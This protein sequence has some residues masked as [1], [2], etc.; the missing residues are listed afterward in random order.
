MVSGFLPSRRR[1]SAADLADWLE[2]DEA[3]ATPLVDIGRTLAHRNHGRTRSVVMAR[4]H[5]EALKGLRAIADNK[6]SPIVYTCDSPDSASAVWLLSG[7]GSQHRK[8]A[9]QL[10]TE[11]PV[12]AAA[13]DKVDALIEDEL[14][15][16]MVEMFLD[17]S[18][19]YEIETSQVGIFT[20]QVGARRAAAPPR[21]RC[22][23]GGRTFDG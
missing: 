22:R 21:R 10:Y 16:S 23:C 8:M 7:F 11:N 18:I 17:D 9:K 4:T 15:Y 12:F 2:T 13:V 20:I 1:K 14:G 19:T 5:D 3:K 6:N